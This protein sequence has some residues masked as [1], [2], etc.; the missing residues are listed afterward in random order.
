MFPLKGAILL[1]RSMLPLNIFE[2][3]YVMMVD[4]A[5]AG[6]RV[7][8]IVQPGQAQDPVESP[9]DKDA[10]LRR[11]AGLGRITSF[12]ETGDGRYLISLSGVCRC[13]LHQEVAM[14][15]SY[16]TFAVTYNAFGDDLQV[17]LGEEDVD[18][19]H[20]LTVL[21]NFLTARQMQT[22]WT[23]ISRSTNEFLVNTLSMLSPYGPEEKQALLEA[24]DLKTRAH[25]LI[26]LA[27]MQLAA[28]DDG[29]G[30]AIQ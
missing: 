20:L 12:T 14:G 11:V 13:E 8:A 10:P 30:S 5:I 26:A 23:A 19:E 15:K 16:R 25:V 3:R 21:R 1:P 7:L 18:R 29:S 9:A 28:P 17:G 24:K 27:E 2:P 4:E 6:A 22:D